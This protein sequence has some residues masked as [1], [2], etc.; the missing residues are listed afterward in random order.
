MPI[1]AAN[2][3]ALAAREYLDRSKH[4]IDFFGNHKD[5]D[6]HEE[7]TYARLAFY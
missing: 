2:Q 3:K 1:A 4:L 7:A 5:D 6:L